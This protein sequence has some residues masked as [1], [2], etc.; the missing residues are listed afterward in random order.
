M[1][2]HVLPVWLALAACLLLIATLAYQQ[3]AHTLR[4]NL[5]SDLRAM[6]ALK[7]GHIEHWLGERRDEAAG[8]NSYLLSDLMTSWLQEGAPSQGASYQ[9]LLDHFQPRQPLHQHRLRSPHDGHLIEELPTSMASLAAPQPD[10]AAARALAMTAARSGAVQFD[11]LH[12]QGDE[13]QQP[14]VLGFFIPIHSRQGNEVLTVLQLSLSAD[15]FLFPLLTRWP[16]FSDTG[17]TLLV[18]RDGEAILYLSPLRH[19]PD[20]PLRLRRTQSLES[21]LAASQILNYGAS[22]YE[23]HDYRGVPSYSYGQPVAGTPWLLAVKIGVAEAMRPLYLTA[24]LSGSLLLL[25]LAFIGWWLY[26]RRVAEQRL[27]A[28]LHDAEDLYQ[29]AP[30][31]YHSLDAEGRIQRINDTELQMLG[32]QREELIGR[33]LLDLLP[34]HLRQS[35]Q[36]RFPRFVAGQQPIEQLQLEL[37]HKDGHY[38]PVAVSATALRDQDGRYVSSS[39]VVRDLSDEF[40]MQAQ[41][42]LLQ[43]AIEASYDAFAIVMPRREGGWCF[44]YCN[45]SFERIT[46]YAAAEVIGRSPK[47]LSADDS[48]Q[49]A[50]QQLYA[51][52]ARGERFKGVLHSYRKDGNSFWA[53]LL[54]DPIRNAHGKVTH[55]VSIL[56]DISAA[57][58]AET[59]LH[60]KREQLRRLA[61]HHAEAQEAERRR[62]ARELHDDLGQRISVLKMHLSL[63]QMH[64]AATPELREQAGSILKIAQGMTEAIRQVVSSL[65]PAALDLGLSG[66][67]EWLAAQY[68]QPGH[69]CCEY[70]GPLNEPRL[71]EDIATACFRIAQEA[72]ANA[73]RHAQASHIAMQLELSPESL[74]LC[75][76]DDGCGFDSTRPPEGSHFGLLGMQERAQALGAELSISS[77]PGQGTSVIMLLLWRVAA[78]NGAAATGPAN[79]APSASPASSSPSA[80]AS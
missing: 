55:Y 26:E 34:L 40:A 46:G 48:G 75:I 38:L 29:H 19:A 14:I 28:A 12:H 27:Q 17:E 79:S 54:L 22:F 72:L 24:W 52:V 18:R 51:A 49:E 13:P 23:G 63:L 77:A 30:C 44:S 53:H 33:P 11:D 71:R 78:S 45:P 1:L 57:R 6:A 4:H 5:A 21:T 39:S 65:R 68:H 47:L 16:G 62:I 67:L 31:G 58:L 20:A 9:A 41:R 69:L 37:R 8:L 25:T 74:R 60:E 36:E 10:R 2:R 3:A 70:H 76:R 59:R 7:A 42:Q 35:F 50:L 80:N 15:D 64:H 32:Y 66:A 43:Q 73:S 56:E 61:Q